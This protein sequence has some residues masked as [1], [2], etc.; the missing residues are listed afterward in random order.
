M[1][2]AYLG[3][4]ANEISLITLTLHIAPMM[5]IFDQAIK[6]LNEAT[7]GPRQEAIKRSTWLREYFRN[8]VLMH[9]KIYL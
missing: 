2:S 1:I 8:I 9:R 3:L 7:T 5:Q 4:A 6:G